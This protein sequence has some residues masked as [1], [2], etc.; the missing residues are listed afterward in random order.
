MLFNSLSFLYLFLPLLLFLIF[1]FKKYRN[2]IL[3]FF[4]LFFYAWGAGYFLLL[5]MAVIVFDYFI[6]IV[7]YEKTGLQ[8][9][10][11]LFASILVNL[12]P[13]L[14]Y[15]YYHFLIWNVNKVS[16]KLDGATF[17]Y[18]E[19]ILPLGISFF[20][21]QCISYIVDVYRKQ[22]KPEKS[23]I[24][25]ALYVSFFPQLIAGP[26]IKYDVL[27]IRMSRFKIT[28]SGFGHG[29]ER[30]LIGLTKKVL[31]ADVLAKVVDPIFSGAY[32]DMSSF[33][34]W[35]GLLFYSLQIY[36][37]FSGYSDMAVGLAKMCGFRLPKNFN[38]PYISLSISEFWTRWHITLGLWF[39]EYLYIPL[40]GNRVSGL[41]W[42][43][44]LFFVF[45]LIGFWHGPNWNLIL[46][47]LSYALFILIEK[48][49]LIYFNFTRFPLF[50]R[51]VVVLFFIILPYVLIRTPSTNLAYDYYVSLFSFRPLVG[52][53]PFQI[54]SLY[55]L[56]FIVAVLVSVP[57][58]EKIIEFLRT[59]SSS[60]LSFITPLAYV[61]VLLLITV[62]L[63][64]NSF[65]PFIYFRF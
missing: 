51:R 56:V 32:T 21:F 31:I 41:R 61:I 35:H 45:G 7:L 15:K 65:N 62:E 63:L 22:L 34:A 54:D 4:S 43:F 28:Y 29:L 10:V 1:I 23:L 55:Y 12:L 44:N 16:Q 39:R 46:F 20:T 58:R 57:W 50:I 6:A 17:H 40:G 27:K 37:D 38:Y 36:F 2:Y 42:V 26:I 25:I 53:I 11:I 19:L 48:K 24:N 59:F 49:I 3:L 5:L 60:M 18:E 64:N 9:K 14:Y 47:G 8:R 33:Q 13:L 30:F 52:S